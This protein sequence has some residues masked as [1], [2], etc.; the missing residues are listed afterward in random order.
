MIFKTPCQQCGVNIEFEDEQANQFV[1]CPACAKPTRLIVPSG[2][3]YVLPPEAAKDN[4]E[5]LIL[6]GYIFSVIMPLVGFIIGIILLAKNRVGNGVGCIVVSVISSV[7]C[8]IIISS[9]LS[10]T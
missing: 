1:D 8:G 2:P 7:I 4:L 10:A 3:K 9:L 5:N 6:A